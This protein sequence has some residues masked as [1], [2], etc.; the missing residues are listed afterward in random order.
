MRCGARC[1]PGA[2]RGGVVAAITRFGA[3][4]PQA[5]TDHRPVAAHPDG[6]DLGAGLAL[7]T[8]GCTA[9]YASHFST[10]LRQD[11]GCW[12]TVRLEVLASARA[13]RAASRDAR[14]SPVPPGGEDG[15]FEKLGAHHPID[16]TRSDY[17]NGRAQHPRP[18]PHRHQLQCGG[19]KQFQ[20]RLAAPEA[21][22]ER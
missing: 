3:Y 18:F 11:S 13:D 12:C 20:E 4:A 10:A 14:C 8:Q 21:M 22:A 15:L 5:V 2:A 19:R 9:W 16:R 1:S 7:T 6:H 17:E